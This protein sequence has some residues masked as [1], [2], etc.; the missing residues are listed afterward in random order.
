MKG[1]SMPSAIITA[2]PTAFKSNGDLDPAGT[3]AA[4]AFAAKSGVDGFFVVGSSAEFAALER[5]ERRTLMELAAE[6]LSDAGRIIAHAGAPSLHQVRQNISDAVSAGLHRIA[7]VTPYYAV[8][9]STVLLDYFRAV[10][11]F[12]DG[13]EVYVYVFVARTGFPVSAED[14]ASISQ[15][16]NICGAKVSGTPLAGVAGYRG[17]VPMPF[18]IMTGS[19]ADLARVAS[20]SIQGIVSGVAAVFPEAFLELRAASEGGGDA[21]ADKQRVVDEIVALIDGNPANVKAALRYRGIEA[22]YC[23]M[24]SLEPDARTAA[25]LKEYSERWS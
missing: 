11:S 1:H 18:E 25:K 24:P 15:M 19:D 2:T 13:L 20:V 22:G 7:V 16:P 21:L 5:P 17:A 12:T 14:L 9:S 10:S 6:E 8:P 4:L 3:R 23:R